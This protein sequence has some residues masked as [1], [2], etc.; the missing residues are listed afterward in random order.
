ML[1]SGNQADPPL[2][3]ESDITRRTFFRRLG[4]GLTVAVPSLYGLVHASPAS[5]GSSD[6]PLPGPCS[7]QHSVYQGHTCGPRNS[8]PTGNTNACIGVYYWYS[9][10]TGQFCRSETVNE[11]R[12]AGK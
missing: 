8:C 12:C 3:A 4:A 10:I 1:K 11:G 2:R 9:S 6:L 5:A 7:I